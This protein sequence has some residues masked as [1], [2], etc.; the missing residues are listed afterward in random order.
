[1]ELTDETEVTEVTE[2]METTEEAEEQE[3][4]E[5]TDATD[6]STEEID[7]SSN[8]TEEA[9][10]SNGGDRLEALREHERIFNE[11]REFSMLFPE[12]DL[13]SLPDSVNDSIRAGVPLAAAYALYRFKKEA[14]EKAASAINEKNR[15]RSFAIKKNDSSDS[16]FSPSEV[17]EMSPAGVKANYNKIIDSMSHW[18]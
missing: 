15:E 12:A 18:H 5:E 6:E 3:E 10:R 16:Y 11:Y 7:P 13:A 1:M 17:K 2:V 8:D 4:V 14:A 9:P